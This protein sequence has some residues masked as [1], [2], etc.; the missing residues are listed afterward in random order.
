MS[1]QAKIEASSGTAT[2]LNDFKLIDCPDVRTEQKS[3]KIFGDCVW[4]PDKTDKVK[5]VNFFFGNLF[6]SHAFLYMKIL[7]WMTI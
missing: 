1:Y 7:V 3:I 6:M 5:M 2:F 4:A